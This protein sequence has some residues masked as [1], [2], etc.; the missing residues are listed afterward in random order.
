[1]A[2]YFSDDERS[3]DHPDLDDEAGER[4]AQPAQLHRVLRRRQEHLGAPRDRLAL[5]PFNVGLPVRVMVWEGALVK[6]LE[7]VT[8]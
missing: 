1:M 4:E 8:A 6:E 3:V 5:D 7:S 2:Y